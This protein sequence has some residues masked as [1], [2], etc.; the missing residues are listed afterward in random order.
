[1]MRRAARVSSRYFGLPVRVPQASLR[2]GGARSADPPLSGIRAKR[3]I[4]RINSVI[5]LAILL[6]DQCPIKYL[7]C[8]GEGQQYPRQI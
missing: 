4:A 8:F 6:A 1:M 7:F 5:K 2:A 3:I